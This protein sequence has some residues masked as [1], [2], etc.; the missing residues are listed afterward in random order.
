MTGDVCYC[1]VE[2]FCFQAHGFYRLQE[3]RE[4]LTE[5]SIIAYEVLEFEL[6]HFESV[7]NIGHQV[8]IGGA[9]L[10][11]DGVD[12][13]HERSDLFLCLVFRNIF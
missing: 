12:V 10:H 11:A 9:N 8:G 2:F 13:V 7:Q 6:V 3:S 5:V 4:S 1:G